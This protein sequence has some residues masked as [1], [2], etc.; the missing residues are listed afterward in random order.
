MP[1]TIPGVA[2]SAGA[3]GTLS[4]EGPV[5]IEDPCWSLCTQGPPGYQNA[6]TQVVRVG[7]RYLIVLQNALAP[8][9]CTVLTYTDLNGTP[10]H[11]SYFVHPGNVNGDGAANS[12][13]IAYLIG[14][15]GGVAPPYGTYSTDINRSGMTTPGD[16]LA[17][18]DVLNGAGSLDAWNNTQRRACGACLPP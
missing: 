7:D 17:L 8:D 5:G 11:A 15:L 1:P 2:G 16:I 13:D 12:N 10:Q 14:V 6:I 9:S 3:I 4:L 18:I